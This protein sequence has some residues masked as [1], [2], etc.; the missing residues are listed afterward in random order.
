MAFISK[1][2][3][4]PAQ[5]VLLQLLPDAQKVKLRLLCGF[6]PLGALLL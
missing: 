3:Q 4:F 6:E 1:A 2:N 5:T